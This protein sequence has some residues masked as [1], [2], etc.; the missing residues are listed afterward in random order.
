MAKTRKKRQTYTEEKRA[1]ILA[2]AQKGGLTAAQV[3]KKYGVTPVTYYSWRKK[4]GVANRRG[5]TAR[6][7]RRAGGDITSQVRSE[8]QSKVRQ[9]LPE[10]VRSEVSS[11]LDSVFG[12]RARR[13]RV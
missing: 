6:V 5:G 10:I 11:Y 3:K 8:V 1:S 13:T 2:A 12:G 9:I 7:A 4:T